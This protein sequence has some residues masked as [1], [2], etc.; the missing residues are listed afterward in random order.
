[1]GVSTY[2]LHHSE[3]YYPDPFDFSPERWIVDPTNKVSAESVARAESAFAAFGLGARGCIGKNLAYMELSLVLARM[4]W[5][6]DIRAKDGDT[7]GEGGAGKALGRTRKG[8]YQ[9]EDVWVCKRSGPVIDL[10][11]R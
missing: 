2:A 9:L 6:Y 1:V 10:K 3:E 7:T 8:E 11:V 4:L 5:L